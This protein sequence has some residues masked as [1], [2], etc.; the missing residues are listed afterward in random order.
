VIKDIYFQEIRC[1]IDRQREV[2]K[3]EIAK[4]SRESFIPEAKLLLANTH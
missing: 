4:I 3:E 1:K 2:L